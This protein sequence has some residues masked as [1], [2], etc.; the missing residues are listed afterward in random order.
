MQSEWSID[1]DSFGVVRIS[2]KL[3]QILKKYR[4]LEFTTPESG[5]VLIG[6]Y[7]NSGGAILIDELTH[8]QL[9]DQQ[10]RCMYYRSTAHNDLV[11]R[12][13]KQT[14]HHSTYVGLWHTHPENIPAY[15]FTDKKDWLNA[16]SSSIYEGNHL[17]FLI[18][19]ISHITCWV[20]SENKKK[21]KIVLAGKYQY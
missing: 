1:V 18:V 12:I 15:S 9:T 19:G 8:P 7:L 3:I 10:G 21:N 4:Q 13:W 17:I 2:L 5:G 11:Q 6:K 16:L 14:H 20:G